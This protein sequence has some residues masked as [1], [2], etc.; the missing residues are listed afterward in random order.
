MTTSVVDHRNSAANSAGLLLI[1]WM[2]GLEHGRLWTIRSPVWTVNSTHLCHV[3]P[4]QRGQPLGS[5]EL[6]D[7]GS[8]SMRGSNRRWWSAV[9]RTRDFARGADL[10]NVGAGGCL[11]G[12]L[13]LH[14]VRWGP[15]LGGRFDT[16]VN[17]WLGLLTVW[18][19][20]AVC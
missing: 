7:Q 1:V 10:G 3:S 2:V 9:E 4:F 13:G 6:G 12:R 8:T 16:V 17:G 19:P 5:Q 11:R 18:A 14:G 20:T 15:A